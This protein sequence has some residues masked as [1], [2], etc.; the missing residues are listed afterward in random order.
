MDE[1][2]AAEIADAEERKQRAIEQADWERERNLIN[3]RGIA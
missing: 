1:I 3:A 2:R